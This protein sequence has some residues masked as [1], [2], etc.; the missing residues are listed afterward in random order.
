MTLKDLR[1]QAKKTA[2]E[3]ADEIGV[4]EN[5]IYNYESGTRSIDI[6]TALRLAN[7]YDVTIE[8]FIEAYTNTR[9]IQ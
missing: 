7:I 1:K 5:A 6:V 9:T 4:T 2:K 3:V 8:E